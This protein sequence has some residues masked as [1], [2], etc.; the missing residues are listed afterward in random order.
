MTFGNNGSCEKQLN[1]NQKDN[2]RRRKMKKIIWVT[3]AILLVSLPYIGVL[4]M[5]EGHT[6]HGSMDHSGHSGKLIREATVDGYALAYHLIDMQEKIKKIKGMQ[7]MSNTHHLMLYIK[8]PH[9]HPVEKAKVGYL[10]QGPTGEKQKAM[11]MSMG[12]GFGADVNMKNMGAYTI[13]TKIVVGDKKMK[14]QFS[15]H[16]H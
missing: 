4:A 15:H 13:K 9:G 10:L 12:G 6:G 2:K 5:E 8:D 7:E 16:M 1:D 11:T 14:D 3:M